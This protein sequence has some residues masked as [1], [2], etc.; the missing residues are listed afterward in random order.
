MTDK[1]VAYVRC[2]REWLVDYL[3]KSKEEE[4]FM[5][6]FYY[7]EPHMQ[8]PMPRDLKVVGVEY[9]TIYDGFNVVFESPDFKEVVK[10]GVVPQVV[11]VFE[12]E[13]E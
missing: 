9:R 3:F 2:S 13:A 6:W 10:D 5:Y 4:R 11:P 12:R 1:R 8:F 7:D